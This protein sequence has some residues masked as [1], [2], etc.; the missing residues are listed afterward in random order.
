MRLKSFSLQKQR[1]I[2]LRPLYACL[3]KRW[4]TTLLDLFGMTGLAPRWTMSVR[5]SSPSYAL[6]A[7]RARIGGL[8]PEPFV[9]VAR[10]GR[11]PPAKPLTAALAEE[12]APGHADHF[13]PVVL[14][15][16]VSRSPHYHERAL[17]S[18]VIC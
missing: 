5:K 12:S 18:G 17:R 2:T 11:P 3:L 10:G 15:N 1:S 6:S 8:V 16:P 9:P 13:A 14:K 4:R 7:M